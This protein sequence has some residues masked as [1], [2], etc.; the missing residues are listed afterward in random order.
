MKSLAA[1]A[2][3]DAQC[4]WLPE[5]ND[6]NRHRCVSRWIKKLEYRE[7]KNKKLK[8]L[9]KTQER[10]NHFFNNQIC[11]SVLGNPREKL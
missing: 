8:P 5:S 1:L 3:T 4:G 2:V 9:C 6:S 11:V 7:Q 10:F